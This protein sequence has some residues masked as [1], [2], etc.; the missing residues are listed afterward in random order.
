MVQLLR[1][2][3]RARARAAL[4]GLFIDLSGNILACH[5][6]PQLDASQFHDHSSDPIEM[7]REILRKHL[8]VADLWRLFAR[9]EQS[10]L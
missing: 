5:A 3:A 10:A 1:V 6:A 7:S 4:V 9:F 8:L 2:R